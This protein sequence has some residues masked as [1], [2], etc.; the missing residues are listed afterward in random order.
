MCPS[1]QVSTMTNFSVAGPTG[2]LQHLLPKG[3]SQRPMLLPPVEE[4]LECTAWRLSTGRGE[5]TNLMEVCE[6]LGMQDP[7]L[8]MFLGISY[9]QG[10][11]FWLLLPRLALLPMPCL[12]QLCL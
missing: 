4:L 7:Y 1:R 8:P 9:P 6:E 11:S 3:Q 2:C 5:V 10:A 12:V